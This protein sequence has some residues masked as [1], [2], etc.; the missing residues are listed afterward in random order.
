MGG[1]GNAMSSMG[2]VAVEV[3]AEEHT[4]AGMLIEAPCARPGVEVVAVAAAAAVAASSRWCLSQRRRRRIFGAIV[5]IL[6]VVA[7]VA[8]MPLQLDA[9]ALVERLVRLLLLLRPPQPSLELRRK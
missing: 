6:V 7:F 4:E 3:V 5:F 1:A 2:E 8:P 9:L